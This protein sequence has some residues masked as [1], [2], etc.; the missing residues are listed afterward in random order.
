MQL[1]CWLVMAIALLTS[2]HAMETVRLANGE[3]PPYVGKELPHGGIG[4]RI[5]SAALAGEGIKVEYVHL[6]WKRGLEIARRGMLD[7]SILWAITPEREVDFLSSDPII[8][9]E[10]VLLYRKN[11]PWNVTKPEQAKGYQIGIPNGYSYETIPTLIDMV[12]ESGKPAA[13]IADDDLGVKALIQERIDVYPIDRNVARW[14]LANTQIPA[15]LI[16]MH[17]RPIRSE[18]LTV[19]FNNKSPRAKWLQQRMNAGLA[20]LRAS[21]QLA[22]WIDDINRAIP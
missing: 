16:L 17:G 19:L 13:I 9:S 7:G 11:K 12:R 20:K 1:G 18:A 6:S 2:P 21:G 22:I 15:G 3:W 10:V 14:V 8:T 4:A 5:I